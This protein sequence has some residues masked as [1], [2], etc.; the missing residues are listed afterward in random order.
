MAGIKD[1]PINAFKNVADGFKASEAARRECV[2]ISI[3]VEQ[4]AP[5]D[6]VLALKAALMP[7]TETGLVHV[8]AL[9]KQNTL[10]INPDCDLAIIVCGSEGLAVG[11]AKAFAQAHIKC[12]LVVESSVEVASDD[13]GEDVALLCASSANALVD[14]LATWMVEA[15]NVDLALAANFDF[16]RSAVTAKC[17]KERSAQNAV[18][19]AIPWGN[20]ADMP[21]MAANQ[22]LMTLDVAGAHGREAG[23]ERLAEAAGVVG[24]AFASR[25]LARKLVGKLPG[26]NWAIKAGIGAGATYAIGKGLELV[27]GVQDAWKKRA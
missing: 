18:I 13:L 1:I 11:A 6:L 10:Q 22:V 19:G 23:T 15:S 27:Y 2:R 17:I 26:L 12:A 7:K 25:A 16:V 21:L 9:N 14:K 5:Q 4:G 8:A 24:A 20:G 3:E